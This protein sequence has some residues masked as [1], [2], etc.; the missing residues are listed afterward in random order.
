[1]GIA[2]KKRGY[3]YSATDQ[4][5]IRAKLV[6]AK[7]VEGLIACWNGKRELTKDQLAIALKCVDKLVPNLQSQELTVVET[8]PFAV[9]PATVEDS[10]QW[11]E[12]FA[13]K[14]EH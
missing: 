5:R 2:F 4:E 1:M 8:Q 11:Q 7:I 6:D 13:P 12:Q 9:L 10:D 3:K 14:T